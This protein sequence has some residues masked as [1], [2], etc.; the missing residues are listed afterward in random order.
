MDR[1]QLLADLQ[2]MQTFQQNMRDFRRMVRAWHVRPVPE[3]VQI[4]AMLFVEDEACELIELICLER[5]GYWMRLRG[6]ETVQGEIIRVTLMEIRL[7]KEIISTEFEGHVS[8]L[9]RD[10]Q[11]INID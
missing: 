8:N 11:H 10:Y 5:N 7:L 4:R 1:D 2:R 9:V 6:T 3:L